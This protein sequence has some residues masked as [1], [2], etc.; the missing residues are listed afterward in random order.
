MRLNGSAL[1]CP[2]RR[3]WVRRPQEAMLHLICEMFIAVDLSVRRCQDDDGYGSS[4]WLKS[5][6]EIIKSKDASGQ[7]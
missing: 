1:G 5:W 7:A 3:Q 4:A 6:S 2:R